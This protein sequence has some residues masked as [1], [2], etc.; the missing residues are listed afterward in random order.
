[1]TENPVVQTEGLTKKYGDFVALDSLSI[2]LDR[3]Q[4]VIRATRTHAE[5]EESRRMVRSEFHYGTFTRHLTLP[6]GVEADD[7]TAEYDDGIL[8]IRVAAIGDD[9]SHTRIAVTRPD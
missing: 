9:R 4:L 8:E 6:A 1:M 5:T 7:I 3:G 2:S